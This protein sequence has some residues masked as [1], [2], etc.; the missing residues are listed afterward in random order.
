VDN[1]IIINKQ[2]TVVANVD[3]KDSIEIN[4]LIIN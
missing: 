2:I 3:I 1:K 4:K